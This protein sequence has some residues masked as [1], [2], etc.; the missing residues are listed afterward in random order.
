[1]EAVR[2]QGGSSAGCLQS[3]VCARRHRG[4]RGGTCRRSSD[5]TGAPRTHAD[6]SAWGSRYISPSYSINDR[7]R[8]AHQILPDSVYFPFVIHFFGTPLSTS[9]E[10]TI[11]SCVP[12]TSTSARD[13][14]EVGLM[15]ETVDGD[16]GAVRTR[17][18]AGSG[19]RT[20][21]SLRWHRCVSAPP[22]RLQ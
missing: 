11:L 6:E 18:R 12:W 10:V 20:Y 17:E 3:I 8:K 19:C 16:Q 14:L 2:G 13:V 21:R 4:L 22:Q 1:M 7:E 15:G 9:K 5:R